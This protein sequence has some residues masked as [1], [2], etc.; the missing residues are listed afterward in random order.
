MKYLLII[1]FLFGTL[2]SAIKEKNVLLMKKFGCS[3][4]IH[5]IY[6]KALPKYG[7][8]TEHESFIYNESYLIDSLFQDFTA[9]KIYYNWEDENNEDQYYLEFTMH[10]LPHGKEL[11]GLRENKFRFVPRDD[12]KY[13]FSY[14]ETTFNSTLYFKSL[15]LQEKVNRFKIKIDTSY[16]DIGI[17]KKHFATLFKKEV[18]KLCDTVKVGDDSSDSWYIF[19]NDTLNKIVVNPYID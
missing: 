19:K 3:S 13:I 8:V 4:C 7:F 15:D 17:S 14:A 16:I 2:F 12:G 9:S 11:I 10:F 18:N 6:T 5:T 1:L